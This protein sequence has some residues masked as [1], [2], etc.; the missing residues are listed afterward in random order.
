MFL[1]FPG[2]TTTPQNKTMTRFGNS[3][4][5]I[6]IELS[7]CSTFS[8]Y[9]RDLAYKESQRTLS[10]G[11][12][13]LGEL[14]MYQVGWNLADFEALKPCLA[15]AMSKR[16]PVIIHVNEPVGH[17]YPGKISV[18]IRALFKTIKNHPN[19]DII[20]AHFGGGFSYTA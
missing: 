17:Q 10:A 18:D 13:G 2:K 7:L 11:F 4:N 5:V 15:L 12:A 9:K 3:T 19:L 20:L 6:P 8:L 1:A 16:V 14:S